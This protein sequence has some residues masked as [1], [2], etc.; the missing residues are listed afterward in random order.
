MDHCSSRTA[1]YRPFPLGVTR[2]AASKA[3][4][5]GNP[6]GTPEGRR[7]TMGPCQPADAPTR[8]PAAPP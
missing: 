5:I 1:S 8:T 3:F 4:T 7:S 6:T 2:V